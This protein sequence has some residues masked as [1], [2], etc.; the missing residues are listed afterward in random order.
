MRFCFSDCRAIGQNRS[1]LS[2]E[3]SRGRRI[4]EKVELLVQPVGFGAIQTDRQFQLGL[5]LVL[6]VALRAEIGDV[7]SLREL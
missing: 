3:K 5:E 2:I 7:G 1:E 4:V 6:G